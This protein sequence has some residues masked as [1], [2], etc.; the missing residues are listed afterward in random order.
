MEK[1]EDFCYDPVDK[2]KLYL[3]LKVCDG[4]EYK[5]RY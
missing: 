2:R 4:V 5:R 1:D 3:T